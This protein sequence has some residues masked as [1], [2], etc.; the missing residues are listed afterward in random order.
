MK[1]IFASA[2]KLNYPL[3][4]K[5]KSINLLN[6]YNCFSFSRKITKINKIFS[7]F[8]IGQKKENNLDILKV[9]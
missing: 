6:N 2:K 3:H 4:R 8:A 5:N 9:I 1:T 7:K